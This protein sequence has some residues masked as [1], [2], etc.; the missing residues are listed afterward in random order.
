MICPS[1]AKSLAVLSYL[2]AGQVNFPSCE[3][4]LKIKRTIRAYHTE[5]PNGTK[6]TISFRGAH[7]A[8]LLALVQSLARAER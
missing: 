4:A 5:Q 6:M 7:G 8:D 2:Q 1:P 3:D